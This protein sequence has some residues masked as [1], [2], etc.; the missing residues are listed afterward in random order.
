M[1]DRLRSLNLLSNTTRLEVRD[2]HQIPETLILAFLD[3]E[4]QGA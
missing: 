4:E 3:R 1:G 2:Y